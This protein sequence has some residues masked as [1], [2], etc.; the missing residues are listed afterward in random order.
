MDPCSKTC[1]SIPEWL[2]EHL[3]DPD[4]RVVEV[5]V[6]SA[7]YDD[8]HIDGAVLWNIYEDLKD[9]D[10][11]AVDAR[12]PWSALRRSGITPET[13]VVFYGYAPA[14]GLWLMKL[15]GH[16]DAR[17]LDCSRETWRT[18]GRPWANDPATDPRRASYQLGNEDPRLRPTRTGRT[19]PSAD[20]DATLV[21][22][23]SQPEYQGERSGLPA[24]GAGG[25]AGHI[26]SALHQPIDGLYDDDG[27]VPSAAL[28]SE[29]GLL[30]RRSRRRTAS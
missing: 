2:A 21:D 26:P 16:P 24:A 12:R 23:R 9:A 1:W 13:T 22:V 15:Y 27:A 4:L 28:S 10:Y 5:D 30:D 19:P 14:L 20:P 18:E 25:R 6:S 3:H 29:P 8:W 7:A 17:I 11:R